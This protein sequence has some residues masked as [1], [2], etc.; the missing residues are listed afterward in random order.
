MAIDRLANSPTVGRIG[1]ALGRS[2][3]PGIGNRLADAI[4]RYLERHASETMRRAIR[5]NQWVVS[6]CQAS[7]AELDRL[8]AGVYRQMMRSFYTLFHYYGKPQA[9]QALVQ[10]PPDFDLLVK[11]SQ[12][13]K[14]GLMLAGL[15]MSHFDLILQ[16]AAQRG[17]RFFAI[18]LPEATP[19]IDWQHKLRRASGVEILPA[20]VENLSLA[21]QRMRA[22]E[23]CV[24]GI[25]Y[26]VP[27]VRHKPT[28]FGRPA[29]LSGHCAMLVLRAGVPVIVAGAEETPEGRPRLLLTEAVSLPFNGDNRQEVQ[30]A[31]E[32]LL[33]IAAR[34]IQPRPQH[35]LMQH[36]VWPDLLPELPV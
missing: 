11:R 35:W 8:Q 14:E 26:P 17:L 13:G 3:S 12:E 4:A 22:G 1:L 2:L 33:E 15:H 18:S 21:V 29:A 34:L 16:A 10:F 30:Q 20:S 7:P 27:G 9:M 36:P 24:T 25:D 31:A 5:L 23:V 19:A 6:G 28:F 32:A